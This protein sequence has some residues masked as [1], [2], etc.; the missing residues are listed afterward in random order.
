MCLLTAEDLGEYFSHFRD[1]SD[2]CLL[3]LLTPTLTD[4]LKL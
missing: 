4:Y 2:V 3:T 1:K